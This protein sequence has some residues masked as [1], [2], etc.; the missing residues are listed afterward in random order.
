MSLFYELPHADPL[1]PDN[2]H[3]IY[4][5]L[6]SADINGGGWFGDFLL[7]DCL[8]AGVVNGNGAFGW[9]VDGDASGCGG[10]IY[11]QGTECG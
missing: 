3:D 2:L 6:Q 11:S 8:T 7:Q 9:C 1:L 10:W 5:A 4:P